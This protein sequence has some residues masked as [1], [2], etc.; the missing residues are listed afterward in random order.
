MPNPKPKAVLTADVHYSLSTL[1]LADA[2]MSQC[3]V[4]ANELKIPLIVAGDLHDSKGLL[5][6]EC[7]S[8]MLATFRQCK[9]PIYIVIG[10]HCR[11]NEREKPHALEFLGHLVTI[12]D[13]PSKYLDLWMVPYESNGI[14]SFLET[15]S[16][17]STIIAHTGIQSAYMGHY[18]RD[19]SSLPKEAFSGQRVISGHY[20]RR[21]DIALPEG[22]LFSYIGNPLTLNYG[23]ALDPPKG[24]QILNHDGSLTFV[25]TNLRKHIVAERHIGNVLEPIPEY[26]PGDLVKIK[27]TGPRSELEKLNRKEIGDALFGHSDFKLDLIPEV[28]VPKSMPQNIPL[29]DAM[30]AIIDATSETPEEKLRLK[31]L[32][33]SLA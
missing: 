27:V 31:E 16:K 26:K 3:V 33:R 9:Q 15:V 7:V 19:T 5:R 1:P 12:V 10:N 29:S 4:K 11:V 28:S 13:T 30:D 23:E 20:H 2:A 25:P 21:Q 8:A 24:Y 17:G 14:G 6:A 32:W 18:T 22:G